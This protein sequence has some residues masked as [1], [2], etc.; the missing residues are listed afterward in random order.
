[1]EAN[2]DFS[3]NISGN[4]I[5]FGNGF[6][7]HV[8][9][10]N[11]SGNN[12]SFGNGIGDY[13]SANFDDGNNTIKLGNGSGDYITIGS[14]VGGSTFVTGTGAN[15]TITIGTHAHADT[16]GFTV[17]TSGTNFTRVF[18]AQSGDHFTLST[19]V[20]NPFLM[21]GSPYELTQ[22]HTNATSLA[23]FI[24]SLGAVD[25][26]NAKVGYNGTNTFI[27]TSSNNHIAAIEIVGSFT[28][29]TLHAG[30]LTLG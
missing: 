10:R 29:T 5:S 6:N 11:I 20:S 8:E 27:V 30:V 25:S 21:S 2:T 9:A 16:F 15:D 14:G 1:V 17:G 19:Q 26:G 12:I 3:G 4:T 7:D 22:V 28:H 13:V 23:G 24:S 18:G